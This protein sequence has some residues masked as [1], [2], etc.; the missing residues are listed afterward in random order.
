LKCN[1]CGADIPAYNSFCP[2]CG[3]Q[4]VEEFDRLIFKKRARLSLSN[5]YWYAFLVCLIESVIVGIF[6]YTERYGSDSGRIGNL[7]QFIHS[8]LLLALCSIIAAASLLSLA[9][10][11]FIANPI[12]AGSSKYFINNHYVH[13]EI[14][15]LFYAFRGR[16]YLRIVGAMAWRTLFTFLWMLLFIIPGIVKAY[17]YC[18][19]PYILADNPEIGYDR[20]L[21]LSM[22]MTNGYKGEIFVLQLSF[23]GW[24]LLGALCLGVGVLFVNPYFGA[25]MAEM[26][27][28]LRDNAIKTGICTAEDLHLVSG[29][30]PEYI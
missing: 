19:V 13:G 11:I 4:Y 26:Y 23:I 3:C 24:Y 14:V 25:T 20:A 27:V 8:P 12:R 5:K 9:Y 16:Q 10:E 21:K 30:G 28:T 1:Q 15:D 6:D 7:D 29:S 2:N 22:S 18:L 17:A